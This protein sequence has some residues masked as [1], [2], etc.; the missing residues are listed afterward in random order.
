MEQ[1]THEVLSL[2]KKTITLNG[3]K[4][5]SPAPEHTKAAGMQNVVNGTVVLTCQP[6]LRQST[7]M[8]WLALSTS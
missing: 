6:T 4:G 8:F 5:E 3:T 7:P 2:K 1:S